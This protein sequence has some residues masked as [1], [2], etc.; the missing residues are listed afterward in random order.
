MLRVLSMGRAERRKRERRARI[1]AK[2]DDVA[3]GILSALESDDSADGVASAGL[4]IAEEQCDFCGDTYALVATAVP[5]DR[6]VAAR[7]G[8]SE[9]EPTILE[10]LSEC[11][12]VRAQLDQ[13]ETALLIKGHASGLAWSAMAAALGVT[14]SALVQRRS[15]R[16]ARSAQAVSGDM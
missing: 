2:R 6:D 15:V 5:P 14:A 1:R 8:A 4:G 16:D 10:S 9:P 7:S 11:R 13:H 3:G 12:A